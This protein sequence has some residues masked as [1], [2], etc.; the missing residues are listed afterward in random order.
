MHAGCAYGRVNGRPEPVARHPA[1]GMHGVRAE[2]R[3]NGPRM[4]PAERTAE[5]RPSYGHTGR[6]W[7]ARS[8]ASGR[9]LIPSESVPGDE[10]C[11]L[12]AALEVELREDRRDVV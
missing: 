6:A 8:P 9:R 1:A 12:G 3:R 7:T 4:G 10:G 5:T 11:G 2:R